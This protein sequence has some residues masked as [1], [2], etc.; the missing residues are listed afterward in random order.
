M[1]SVLFYGCGFYTDS[2]SLIFPVLFYYLYLC[3]KGEN[4]RKKQIIYLAAMGLSLT[5]GMMIKFTV[6]IVLIAVVID[7]FLYIPWKKALLILVV[8][9]AFYG[10]IKSIYNHNLYKNYI[11]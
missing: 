11:R 3:L 6:V 8:S 10:V 7:A 2:L 4:D 1:F 9:L 5:I